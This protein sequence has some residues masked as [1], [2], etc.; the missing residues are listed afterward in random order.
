LPGSEPFGTMGSIE[1]EEATRLMLEALFDIRTKVSE[2]HTEIFGEDD[3]EEEEEE[4][5]S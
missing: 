3:G 5:N 2:I 4:E 1:D